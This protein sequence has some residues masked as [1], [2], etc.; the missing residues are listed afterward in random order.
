MN[1]M[2]Q[3]FGF[4]CSEEDKKEKI[5]KKVKEGKSLDYK[6]Q[7]EYISSLENELAIC[8]KKLKE[9]E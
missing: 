8:K 3:L 5:L 2:C 4:K 9:C 7:K 6:E 1:K